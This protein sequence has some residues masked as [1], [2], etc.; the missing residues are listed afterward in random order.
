MTPLSPFS[1]RPTLCPTMRSWPGGPIKVYTFGWSEAFPDAGQHANLLS[2]WHG[3]DH[4]VFQ[5]LFLQRLPVTLQTLLW[6]QEPGDIRSLAAGAD[7][8]LATHK[9]Q[10]HDLVA[11]VNTAE[12]HLAQTA[13]VLK[14]ESVKKKK[15]AGKKLGGRPLAAGG[16]QGQRL[17]VLAPVLVY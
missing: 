5:F 10:S 15:F 1:L 4:H 6:E 12:E 11:H 14:K 17:L 2:C 16:G 7:R 9:P 8:L 3:T 13:A